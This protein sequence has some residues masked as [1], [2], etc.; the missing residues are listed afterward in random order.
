MKTVY[1]TQRQVL[2]NFCVVFL[3]FIN[4]WRIEHNIEWLDY[5]SLGK[6]FHTPKVLLIS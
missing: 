1:Q 5:S 6:L 3:T 4:P 2:Q